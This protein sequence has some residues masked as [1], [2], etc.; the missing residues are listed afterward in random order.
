[1]RNES[2]WN[3]NW[4][5]EHS[6]QRGGA[7]ISVS[8]GSQKKYCIMKTTKC[9][10]LNGQN[11]NQSVLDIGHGQYNK[12]IPS[13]DSFVSRVSAIS[14]PIKSS[15]QFHFGPHVVPATKMKYF[16]IMEFG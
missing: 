12:L 14:S 2:A 1:M 8:E 4:I 10:C 15:C 11:V 7:A 5:T 16:A 13:D 6:N 3:P 9:T